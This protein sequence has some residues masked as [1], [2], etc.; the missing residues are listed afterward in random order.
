MSNKIAI[1]LAE[2]FEE[3]EA[4]VPIDVL[5]RLEF[6]L[7]IAGFEPQITGAHGVI[8]ETDA[9]IENLDVSDFSTVILPG[10]LPGATNLRDSQMVIDLVRKMYDAGKIVA[11]ICAAPIALSAAGIMKGKTCTGYPM[12]LVK[13]ALADANYT[14]DKV[15]RDGN[16]ITGKG[17]G[18][19]FDFAFEIAKALGK[20]A[21]MRQ[22][23]KM[24]FVK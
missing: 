23:K 11:A 12:P 19:A 15:E 24:M 4:I 10:G 6:D 1:L 18:A 13:D 7:V 16:V 21:Q 14:A 9:L 17:P 3:I 5:R 22:L 8:F 20:E 2:G